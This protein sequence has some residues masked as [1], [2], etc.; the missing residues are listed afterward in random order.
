[1]ARKASVQRSQSLENYAVCCW[2]SWS[3]KLVFHGSF[4]QTLVS[5]RLSAFPLAPLLAF[6]ELQT[7]G[8]PPELATGNDPTSSPPMGREHGKG[9][10]GSY[11]SQVQTSAE[12]SSMA[13]GSPPGLPLRKETIQ[14]HSVPGS[15]ARDPLIYAN[16]CVFKVI[17]V[18]ARLEELNAKGV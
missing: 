5:L 13:S 17:G 8:I 3:S 6:Q 7:S 9:P 10:R 14:N 2:T 1:M 4:P 16:S 11:T 18:H 12:S 15:R